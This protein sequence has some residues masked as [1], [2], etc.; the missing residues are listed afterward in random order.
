MIVLDT[1]VLSEPFRAAPAEAV[2][3]W[4]ARQN[5]ASLYVATLSV[6]EVEAG[7]A[8]M[9]EG[10]R[11]ANLAARWAAGRAILAGRILPFDLAAAVAYGEIVARRR[12]LGRPIS[13]FD[14]AIAAVAHSRGA[15]I[16]TRDAAGFAECG[17]D[18]VN[19]W[20]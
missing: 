1:N 5:A 20:A 3:A 16:A 9:P 6:A 4:Y 7:I 11:R 17:V 8:V 13:P 19:P 2:M 15:R 14:A 12:A 10:A 18:L